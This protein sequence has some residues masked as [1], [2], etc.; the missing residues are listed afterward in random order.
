MKVLI[1]HNEYKLSGGEESSVRDEMSA[2]IGL[3]HQVETY[4][5]K[6]A[7]I[8]SGWDNVKAFFSSIYNVKQQ[9]IV[10]S[11]LKKTRPDIVHVHNFFPLISPSVFYACANQGIPCVLSLHNYRILCPST[12]LFNN[13][14]VYL[15]GVNRNYIQVIKDRVYR[16][17]YLGTIATVLMIIVHRKLGTWSK[18]DN[19][20][21]FSNFQKN[22]MAKSIDGNFSILKH[23]IASSSIEEICPNSD[24][25]ISVGRLSEEKGLVELLAN[26]PENQ[27]LR[28]LGSGSQ[29]PQIRS[30]VKERKN[31]TLLGQQTREQV[32]SQLQ[33]A[34]ALVFSPICHETFGLV[35]IESFSTGTPV[36]YNDIAP[37]DEIVTDG[38][39]GYKF[40]LRDKSSIETA[41]TNVILNNERVSKNCLKE[42]NQNY[43]QSIG[44]LRLEKILM[45]TI[46]SRNTS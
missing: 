25:F 11:K 1:V 35:T 18:I 8:Q 45:K 36:I 43:S 6:N 20:I 19:I 21:V 42:F 2:L 37:L 31:I 15:E 32:I 16:N 46:R 26:W 22:L 9:I 23:F 7:E 5:V 30:I 40:N 41:I 12:I 39:H 28:I 10:E 17:S 34:I 4:I 44:S 38:L 13:G 3:G 29:E 24:Y 27:K 14:Q 33:N